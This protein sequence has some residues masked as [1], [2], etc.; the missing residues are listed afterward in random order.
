MTF[1]QRQLAIGICLGLN[2]RKIAEVLGID[3]AS[4]NTM[5][6]RLLL[7]AG[8]ASRYEFATQ[9]NAA[10]REKL[11]AQPFVEPDYARRP[12]RGRPRRVA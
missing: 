2:G 12:R 1:Q 3:A 5:I 11:Y 10:V 8:M 9:Q 4:A 7:E 6:Y